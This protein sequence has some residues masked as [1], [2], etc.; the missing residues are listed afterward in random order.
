MLFLKSEWER[1]SNSDLPLECGSDIFN[2]N[3]PCLPPSHVPVLHANSWLVCLHLIS[4]SSSGGAPTRPRK[5]V[6]LTALQ[7]VTDTGPAVAAIPAFGA[8]ESFPADGAALADPVN[9]ALRTMSGKRLKTA[10]EDEGLPMAQA[11]GIAAPE[12]PDQGGDERKPQLP[13]IAGGD[14]GSD[15]DDADAVGNPA[16]FSAEELEVRAAV[17]DEQPEFAVPALSA[18]RLAFGERANCRV[19]ACLLAIAAR[20]SWRGSV[21]IHCRL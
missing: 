21:Q 12:V 9:A 3:T 13:G 2:H 6:A 18:V 5:R 19:V 11:F 14:A 4:M 1:V 20:H 10:D 7:Q 16:R 8:A 15:E 17:M